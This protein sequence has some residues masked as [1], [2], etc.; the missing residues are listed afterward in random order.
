MNGY[1]V[2]L[3]DQ[4]RKAIR[5]LTRREQQL[6]AA[7]LRSDLTSQPGADTV[8]ISHD[9]PHP[10][11]EDQTYLAHAAGGYI[12]IYRAMQ[13]PELGQLAQEQGSHRPSSRG[14]IV[15]D[16]IPSVLSAP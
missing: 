8:V 4:A 1:E 7:W 6:L 13:Q 14:F 15:F 16:V 3:S 10:L 12:V 11:P 9:V 5:E 2:V